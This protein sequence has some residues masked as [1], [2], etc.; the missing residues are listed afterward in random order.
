MKNPLKIE[1]KIDP[2]RR[3]NT[4]DM[5]IYEKEHGYSKIHDSFNKFMDQFLLRILTCYIV[6]E[7]KSVPNLIFYKLYYLFCK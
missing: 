4:K 2:K 5:D 7:R 1:P 3:E 6:N